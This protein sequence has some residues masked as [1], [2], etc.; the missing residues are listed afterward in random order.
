MP[1]GPYKNFNDCKRKN[2]GKVSDVDAFCG[3]LKHKIE[4]ADPIIMQF[5]AQ[6]D[7]LRALCRLEILATDLLGL[8]LLDQE[9]AEAAL[10]GKSVWKDAPDAVLLDDHR[11]T[12]MW[13]NTLKTGKNLFINK[14]QLKELH[15]LIVAEMLERRMDSGIIHKTPLN[16][17]VMELGTNLERFLKER[18]GFL[19]DPTFINLVGSTVLGKEGADLDLMV[20]S[21]RNENYREKL[22]EVVSEDLKKTVD[23]VWD[24]G[25]PNGP[26]IPVYE[27]WAVPVKNPKPMEPTYRISPMSPIKPARPTH[28]IDDPRDLLE[29]AYYVVEMKGLRM[30]IH[31]KELQIIAFGEDLEEIDLPDPLIES[32][33]SIENPRTFIT[34]GYLTKKEG[35]YVYYMLD[36][37]WWDESEHLSLTIQERRHFM[38]KIPTSDLIQIAPSLYFENRRDTIAYLKDESGPCLVMPNAAGYPVTGNAEWYLY[39]RDEGLKLAEGADTKIRDLVDSRKWEDTLADQRFSLMTKRKQV[40]PLYPFAQMKTTKKGYS[41]REVFGLKSVEDLATE[42]FRVPSKQAVEVKVDGF[43]VQLHKQNDEAKIFTESGHEITKQLPSIEADIKRSAAKS[44]VLDAEATPYDEELTNLGRAGAVPAFTKGA[45]RPVDDSRWAIHTFDV[46]YIDGEEL[47]SKPYEERRARLHG[48]EF[49]V[50]DVPKSAADFKFHIWENVVKWATSADKMV[51]LAGEVSKVPGSE[52]A[53]FK[54]ADSK[55]RLSGNTPLWSK[56]KTA[57]EVDAL[58]VGMDRDGSTYNYTGAIGPVTLPDDAKPETVPID[59]KNYGAFVKWKGKIYTIL[60]KTFNTKEEAKIG[61]IIRVSVKDIRKIDENTY[62]WFHPQVLEIRED[63]T[64]PDPTQTAETISETAKQKQKSA[65][66]L[67]S[68]RYGN[69][70]PLACCNA[71]WLAIPGDEFTY[72][73]NSKDV[74]EKIKSLGIT[75]IIGTKT[76]RDLLEEMLEN[77]IDFM[78]NNSL[79]LGE[80]LSG[81]MYL[82]E[83]SL[84]NEV[85]F[86]I[87]ELRGFLQDNQNKIPE[88]C[89]KLSCG[90][91]VPLRLPLKLQDVYM[92]YPDGPQRWSL[93]LHV[94]GLSVHGDLRMTISKSQAIGWTLDAG[95]SLIRVLLKQLKPVTRTEA[96]ITQQDMTLPL[97][98]L[99]KKLNS[100]PQGKKLKKLLTKK[101]QE[102]PF[103]QIK[104]L[105][106]E[107]WNDEI[108]PIL[109]DPN[110]KIL[111]QRK[112]S[113]SPVWLDYEQ[114]IP[115]GAVGAT[116]ELEGQLVIL[117]KGTVEWGTQKPYFHEYFLKGDKIG[118]RKV[119]MRKIP[120]RKSWDVKEAFAWLTFFT[121]PGEIPYAIS[122]RAVNQNWMPPKGVSALPKAVEEQ[123]P[124][125]RQYWK[126]KNAKEV[127]NALVED[128]KKKPL[129]LAVGLKFAVKRVWHKGPEVRRGVPVTRYLLILHDGQKVHDAFDFGR[130][131][132]PLEQDGTVSR[133]RTDA[134]LK[135]LLPTTG[136]LNPVHSV[137]RVKKIKTEFDTSDEGKVRLLEDSN[138]RLM[139]QFD[140]KT[141]KGRYIFVRDSGDSWIFQKIDTPEKKAMRLS[142]GRRIIQCG[143]DEVTVAK[144]GDLLILTGP[145]IKPG[146]VIPMDGKPSFFTKQG[147]KAFWPSMYRQPIVVMHGE[148]KGDVVGFVNKRWYDDNTGW[149]WVEAVIWHPLAMQL[150]LDKKL[151]SFS[152]EVMPETVWDPEHQ[153][154]HVIGGVCE[155]LAIVPKGACV[156]CTPV[157]ARMGTV[158]DLEGKVYKFGMTIPQFLEHR[159]YGLSMSTK[160]ISEEMGIPRSTLE[161]WM[162]RYNIPRRDYTESRRLRASKETSWGRG[163]IS[164][165][166]SGSGGSWADDCAQCREAEAGGKSRRNPT[167]TLFSN[168]NEHLLVDAPKGIL[169]MVGGRRAIPKYVLIEHAGENAVGGLHELRSL[170]PIV[171]ASK[172]TWSKIRRNY[173]ALSK[174]EARFEEVYNFKRYVITPGQSFKMGAYTVMPIQITRG[175]SGSTLG[176]K[177]QLGGKVVW[178]GSDVLSMPNQEILKDI[179]IYIGDGSTLLGMEEQIKWAQKAE[180]PKIFFTHLGHVEKS[181]EELDEVLKGIAPNVEALHDGVNISLGGSNPLAVFPDQFIGGLLSGEIDIIVRTKPYSEYAK[182]AIL[183]GNKDKA[184]ALYVEG[185]PEK[186]SVQDAKNLKHGLSEKEWKDIIGSQDTVWLYH[187]RILKRLE[188]AREV[189]AGQVAGPYI[190][191]AE[192]IPDS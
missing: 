5:I 45:K 54:E 20:H 102:M 57:F 126:A 162:N 107:L 104:A 142:S 180:I 63:K 89:M 24:S 103:S 36:L 78:M 70:S 27:L 9:T 140:G 58:V 176:F 23:F 52:G 37:P 101:V 82:Q 114:E 190:H 189:R 88:L 156:T 106:G 74:F 41:E 80:V 8:N 66:Y 48:L 137:S 32:V 87:S 185:F 159:Y 30:M 118:Q 173:K 26:Y 158:A 184:Y 171:F 129:K 168:G 47:H 191:D 125:D 3:W 62:H 141:L 131:A 187:P 117:D 108:V 115:P 71:P 73:A 16:I 122:R 139:I 81:P 55:Y 31:R 123:I 179:D 160:E 68:A 86:S 25:K 75:Q 186:S 40:E 11:W 178:H 15:D 44:F 50:R 13:A 161:S 120:T 46:L 165:L 39:K 84:P 188:P 112:S 95:K 111:T 29:D 21:T 98:D 65:A 166:G 33:L 144:K 163:E 155:G 134:D 51:Q 116:K 130:D 148:L 100:T 124:E 146:E 91:F 22:L 150:I 93:Q 177:I 132:N 10:A 128:I 167:S 79:T 77:G 60:G 83:S 145:A 175:K 94:R 119:V 64:H 149:A 181:Y 147:I 154:D 99:S 38:N 7:F 35:K 1:F 92:T 182:Q 17:S 90:G 12:H 53:M 14:Q 135:E 18:K 152:I 143:T 121:K 138:N 169:E 42:L 76:E 174:Q 127:R 172:S 69:H 19:V 34:D 43:R 109:K 6:P 110:K 85:A 153:H 61:D 133:R 4:G 105:V 72:L 96:G 157:E 28:S 67:V 97:K 113:M 183:L 59:V 2:R 56:M 151:G 170:N 192:M 164:I 136:E 49:P